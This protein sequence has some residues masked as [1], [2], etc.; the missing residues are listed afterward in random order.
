M[1][2]LSN[3]GSPII[4]Y[5][6]RIDTED[7]I[8]RKL[9]TTDEEFKARLLDHV[10]I[11]EDFVFENII[12]SGQLVTDLILYENRDY[13]SLVVIEL[14]IINHEFENHEFKNHEFKNHEFENHE[15]EQKIPV[16]IQRI[17][18]HIYSFI[19]KA[20]TIVRTRKY[21]SFS[22]TDFTTNFT[23]VNYTIVVY[24]TPLSSP[25]LSPL[26]SPQTLLSEIY[27]IDC[28]SCTWDGTSISIS[29]RALFSIE[30][31]AIIY[32]FYEKYQ[33]LHQLEYWFKRGMSIL[34]E[35]FEDFQ[36]FV[37]C[38]NLINISINYYTAKSIYI[39]PLS[40]LYQFPPGIITTYD[41]V[42]IF[43]LQPAMILN[44]TAH[45]LR[46]NNIALKKIFTNE[47]LNQIEHEYNAILKP[48]IERVNQRITDKLHLINV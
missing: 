46:S 39:K 38:N 10:P 28:D 24:I 20:M 11:F 26:S 43:S 25:I 21:I 1:Y 41:D 9:V 42:D 19:Q 14:Y 30:N 18:Q 5:R 35:D 29:E 15:F 45:L 40:K 31:N 12:M 2:T 23:F 16:I 27:E 17:Q 22:F 37:K 13:T 8:P 7:E 4:D 32:S 3:I 48:L 34:V 44:D 36:S 47:E 33:Y 6:I